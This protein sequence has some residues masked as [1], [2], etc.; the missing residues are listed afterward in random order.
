[1][2]KQS[3]EQFDYV[4]KEQKRRSNIEFDENGAHRKKTQYRVK[5]KISE[6]GSIS[7]EQETD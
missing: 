5:L 7:I 6:D 2:K 4:Q 1:M 3:S